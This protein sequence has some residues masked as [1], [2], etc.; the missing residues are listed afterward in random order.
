L[1]VQALAQSLLAGVAMLIGFYGTFLG[2]MVLLAIVFHT[3][4]RIS[5]R[6][7]RLILWLALVLLIYFGISFIVQALAPL[8]A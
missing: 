2:G 1:L 4:G 7:T 8:F 6:V 5:A 3:V